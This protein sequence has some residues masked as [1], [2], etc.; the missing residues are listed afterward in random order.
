MAISLDSAKA[1]LTNYSTNRTVLARTIIT[2]KSE[3][4]V[5]QTYLKTLTDPG[6]IVSQNTLVDAKKQDIVATINNFTLLRKSQKDSQKVV[7][8]SAGISSYINTVPSSTLFTKTQGAVGPRGVSGATGL[9]GV[10]GPTGPCNNK[11][12]TVSSGSL[13]S[14]LQ[15]QTTAGTIFLSTN[16]VYIRVLGDVW[17]S[18]T[19]T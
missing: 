16:T 12:L 4:K 9:V 6:Q 14:T 17:K 2:K 7:H 13:A 18:V 11:C 19:L 5:L 3:L 15:N 10:V 8:E 1:V